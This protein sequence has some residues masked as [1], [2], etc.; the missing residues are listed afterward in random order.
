MGGGTVDAAFIRL[1][2]N[3]AKGLAFMEHTPTQLTLALTHLVSLLG[4]GAGAAQS[5]YIKAPLLLA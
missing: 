3:E 5:P 2:P 1:Y 4:H